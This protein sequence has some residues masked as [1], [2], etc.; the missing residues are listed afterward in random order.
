MGKFRLFLLLAVGSICVFTWGFALAEGTRL[1]PKGVIFPDGTV[2]STKA[3]EIGTPG[4]EGPK[5]EK[6][7]TGDTGP[8]GSK[9]DDGAT[10]PQGATGSQGAKGDTGA[11][12]AKGDKGDTGA[13]GPRGLGCF[14]LYDGNDVFLGYL[15]DS[16]IS[17]FLVY[18]PSI[19]GLYYVN[20]A[21]GDTA[22]QPFLTF[23]AKS[24]LFFVSEDCSGQA[25]GGLSE[26]TYLR[27]KAK[28]SDYSAKPTFG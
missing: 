9:G 18:N 28:F 16:E 5:G 17:R 12:G 26:K 19:P 13:Q 6:G 15:I 8:Q 11:T 14:G 27:V 1:T 7:D 22:G 23:E 24:D 20:P 21:K 2:Q 3:A 25:Y 10:G 4:P